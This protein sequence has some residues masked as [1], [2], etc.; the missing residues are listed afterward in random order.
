VT[1][2]ER[3]ER[4][5]EWMRALVRSMGPGPVRL[6]AYEIVEF[7]GFYPTR[8]P[9]DW[10]AQMNRCRRDLA[11]LV[12]QYKARRLPGRPARWEIVR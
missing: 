10:D 3:R 7:S 12:E 11:V 1:P 5:V 8:H 6:S 4:L 2:P 9:T